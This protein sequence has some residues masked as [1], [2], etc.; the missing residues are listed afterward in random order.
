M[1]EPLSPACA[2]CAEV[3]FSAEL[4]AFVSKCQVLAGAV[5][6]G[7]GHE[8]ARQLDASIAAVPQP[9]TPAHVIMLRG[10]LTQFAAGHRSLDLTIR[11]LPPIAE[12]GD[13]DEFKRWLRLAMYWCD[14]TKAAES[15]E[16]LS[17]MAIL[18][19]RA[20]DLIDR[21]Y[22]QRQ[23]NVATAAKDL[24]VSPGYLRRV[25]RAEFGASF[26]TLL[27]QRR[28]QAARRMLRDSDEQIQQIA[29]AVG[30][31][32]SSAFVRHFTQD[33]GITPTQLRGRH[34]SRSPLRPPRGPLPSQ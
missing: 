27:R 12:C 13:A 6:F 28:I 11:R 5:V 17:S 20:A 18:A 3:Q 1:N 22:H 16:P 9:R 7:G 26:R 24:R 31:S 15:P 25:V 4:Q 14:P 32:S 2:Q 21:R 19:G 33:C 23:L 8:C 29:E 34:R 30:Y 10:L